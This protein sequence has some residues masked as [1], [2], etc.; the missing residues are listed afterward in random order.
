MSS[1]GRLKIGQKFEVNYRD[2]TTISDH[3][4]CKNISHI[5]NFSLNS[6]NCILV[7]YNTSKWMQMENDLNASVSN[8]ITLL[9]KLH[10][11]WQLFAD[12]NQKKNTK[13]R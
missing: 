2:S 8:N 5:I 6:K 9:Y 12:I 4:N 11:V 13:D 7:E 10:L 3:L 1:G